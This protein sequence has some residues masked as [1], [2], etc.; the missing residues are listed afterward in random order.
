ML[1]DDLLVYNG[2]LNK[3]VNKKEAINSMTILFSQEESFA[4]LENT[5]FVKYDVLFIYFFVFFFL[6]YLFSGIPKLEKK[7]C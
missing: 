7:H 1:V 4:A 6:L 3:Y 2:E 5:V